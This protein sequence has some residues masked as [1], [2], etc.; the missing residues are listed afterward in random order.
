MVREMIPYRERK[1][2]EV[3]YDNETTKFGVLIGF[4]ERFVPDW[5]GG[6][7]SSTF[8]LVEMDNGKFEW[9][10]LDSI[11]VISSERICRNES[12]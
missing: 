6:P 2:V 1:R 8:A 7:N 11:R 4:I 5:I 10:G 9:F 12:I 3:L